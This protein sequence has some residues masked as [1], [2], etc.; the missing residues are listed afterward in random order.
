MHSGDTF[1]I[2]VYVCV[3]LQT[4]MIN[5]LKELEFTGGKSFVNGGN[6]FVLF[7]PV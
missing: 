3:M 2:I 4:L 5:E 1:S 7:A 6:V